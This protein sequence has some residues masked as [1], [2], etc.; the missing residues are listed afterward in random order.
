MLWAALAT[1]PLMK[2][3]DCDGLVMPAQS[4]GLSGDRSEADLEEV[5]RRR[6]LS[7]GLMKPCLATMTGLFACNY[8]IQ[9]YSGLAQGMTDAMEILGIV[10]AA[11]LFSLLGPKGLRNG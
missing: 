2:G 4:V 8:T 1:P 5:Y 9:H 3:K 10:C 7:Y 6:S 11:A